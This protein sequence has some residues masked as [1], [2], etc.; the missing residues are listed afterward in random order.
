MS[1]RPL[2]EVADIVRAHGAAFLAQAGAGLSAEQRRA[3]RDVAA[4][5]SAALGGHVCACTQCGH[6]DISY[7]SCR[8]RHCPKCLGSQ[9]AAWLRRE[10]S[11][12]LPVDYYHVVFTLPPAVAQVLWQ[13]R[14][15]GYTLLFRAVSATLREVAADPK[16]L[17]AQVGVL[18]VLHTWG[19]NLHYHPHVH[20]VVTGGGLSCDAAGVVAPSP[21]WVSCRPGFLLPVRV[22][23]R[24]YRGKL[25]A[26]LRQAYA[27]GRLSW[28]GDLAGLASP[29]AFA[30]WLAE[31]YRTDWVVYAKSPFGG[32]DQVLKYLAR[33][34]HRVALSNRRLLSL[35]D[36]QVAFEAKDY[37]SGGRRR[38]VTLSADEF[39]RRWVQH[40][41]PRG[42]VKVRHYGLLANRTR[43]SKLA[44]CRLLLAVWV[45]AQRVLA[46]LLPESEP[47]EKGTGR[48]RCPLCGA[49]PWVVVAAVPRSEA[50][51]A[52][53]VPDTS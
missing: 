8:N 24:V 39:L 5:R 45:A 30:A 46:A 3:L 1:D 25:L 29:A 7:N 43:A 34:T 40:V 12:L 42:L 35:A 17:G 14:R 11:Y 6:R 52:A 19:Q 20:C 33:Y 21:R 53:D 49:G 26:F 18:A 10:A 44:C 28:Y 13:N 37:A 27:A 15:L 32:P 9:S 31:Q 38:V 50:S 47:A 48:E 41:L 4:C 2:L 36:G 16:H 23:S 22:L 51:G